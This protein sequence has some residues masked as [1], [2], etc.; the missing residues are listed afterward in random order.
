MIRWVVK[1][2]MDEAN[3]P[4]ADR[5]G[6]RDRGMIRTL[7]AGPQRRGEKGGSRCAGGSGGQATQRVHENSLGVAAHTPGGEGMAELVQEDDTEEI[8]GASDAILHIKEEG[9]RMRMMLT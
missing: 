7:T 6:A 1:G 3:L 4:A 9:A 8:N 2:K 5:D